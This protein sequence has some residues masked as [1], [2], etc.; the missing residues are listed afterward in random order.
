MN[1]LSDALHEWLKTD[2]GDACISGTASDQ[3]LR[4]RIITA[5]EAGWL[6]LEQRVKIAIDE[7]KE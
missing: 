2:T 6:A 4:N 5:F 3:Y 1:A 7:V